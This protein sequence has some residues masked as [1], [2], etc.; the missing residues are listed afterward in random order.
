MDEI[1]PNLALSIP[2]EEDYR[3][4][5]KATFKVAFHSK[6]DKYQAIRSVVRA[7]KKKDPADAK[8]T[9][10]ALLYKVR[11]ALPSHRNAAKVSQA[12]RG[13]AKQN[14][15]ALDFTEAALMIAWRGM[16]DSPF[17]LDKALLVEL[18]TGARM[19]EVLKVSDFYDPSVLNMDEE[20]V[21]GKPP[22]SVTQSGMIVQHKIA[23]D[24]ETVEAKTNKDGTQELVKRTK[25]DMGNFDVIDNRQISVRTLKPK[26][27]LFKLPPEYIRYLVY[28]VIRPELVKYLKTK[29]KG[30]YSAENANDLVY[31]KATME[32][33]KALTN[34]ISSVA[35]RRTKGFFPGSVVK[36]THTLRN[37]YANYSYDTIADKRVTRKQVLG[38]QTGALFTSISYTGVTI[39]R[40]LVLAPKNWENDRAQLVS[41]V[42]AVEERVDRVVQEKRIDWNEV[43]IIDGQTIK[44]AKRTRGYINDRYELLRDRN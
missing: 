5:F 33:N 16:Y 38:H 26:P 29:S 24:R 17:F 41:S 7:G 11:F 30:R 3:Q 6:T 42:A 31:G 19:I 15:G 25:K 27:I 37:I 9:A 36:G 14:T 10:R 43:V 34:I 28:G 18:A 12:N 22:S 13:L 21:E 23:K 1:V 44:K 35:V 40:P 8:A 20:K 4:Q 32:S 39:T 2:S